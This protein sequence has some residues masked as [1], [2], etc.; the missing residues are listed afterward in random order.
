[1]NAVSNVPDL[2][3]HWLQQQNIQQKVS[4]TQILK[5]EEPAIPESPIEPN[6]EEVK[7]KQTIH[8][9]EEDEK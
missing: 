1:M 2:F 5:S 3:L 7:E 4:K 6:V 8:Q 9:S